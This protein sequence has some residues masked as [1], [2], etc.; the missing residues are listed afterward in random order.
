MPAS[1]PHLFCFGLG[2]SARVLARRLRREGWRVAGTCRGG[3]GAE[4][5]RNEGFA[6]FP[7]DRK[8]PLPA[9]ALAG[10]TH[11]LVSIP[12]EAEGDPVLDRHGRDIAALKTLS[13]L[14]YL[15]TTAVYGDCGGAWVDESSPR[16]GA[17]LRA[18]RRAAAE[19]AWLAL[20]RERAVPAHIFRLAAIYGPGRSPFEAL[21][22][23]TAKRIEKPGQVFSRIHVEDLAA[24]LYASMARPRPG[25][26]Y[27]VA[28][29]EPAPAEAVVAYAASLLGLPAPPL[30][31]LEEAALS[32]LAKSF[33][34]DNRRVRNDRIKEELGVALSYPDYRAG[35]EAILRSP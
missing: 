10:A 23:A 3:E 22:S 35:L 26:L 16:L 30:V 25:A 13:W 7:F 6:V 19:D 4:A 31:P 5:W 34:D 28:D 29:D 18:R 33:Y 20:W 24:V 27:N 2:Y 12:P 15:S 17:S 14:G 1:S 11:I 21:R 32:P 9:S 8:R